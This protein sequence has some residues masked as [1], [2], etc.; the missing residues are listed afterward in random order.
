MTWANGN[1]AIAYPRVLHPTNS[2]IQE[3]S[4]ADSGKPHLPRTRMRTTHQGGEVPGTHQSRTTSQ[5]LRT[6]TPG[7]RYRGPL[8]ASPPTPTNRLPSQPPM[9]RGPGVRPHRNR[10]RPHRRRPHQ[11][12]PG[13]V[14][15]ASTLQTPPLPQN[16]P[17]R[18][19]V[20]QHPHSPKR[21][22]TLPHGR[23]RGR[24]NLYAG[25]CRT[26]GGEGANFLTELHDS[27]PAPPTG[28]DTRAEV[29]Q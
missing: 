1:H 10:L 27:T 11:Q 13:R 7:H 16:R 5:P 17:P 8:R 6:P 29:T 24:L 3:A 2:Q 12:P 9:V 4:H 26:R 20:R 28:P 25:G 22:P 21:T 18:R 14:Q 15:L 23:G 19:R